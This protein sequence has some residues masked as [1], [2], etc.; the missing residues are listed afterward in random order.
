MVYVF[1]ENFVVVLVVVVLML[2]IVE[3]D[4]CV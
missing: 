1:C 3:V 4:F 2:V